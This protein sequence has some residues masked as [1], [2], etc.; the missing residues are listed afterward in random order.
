MGSGQLRFDLGHI[1]R[2]HPFKLGAL[3]Q[4]LSPCLFDGL[5]GVA[6]QREVVRKKLLFHREQLEQR[7][8]PRPLLP[9]NHQ[10][11]VELAAGLIDAADPCHEELAAEARD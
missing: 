2:S 3:D 4:K 6:A 10:H 1:R 5:L 11:G 7:R 8:F 9:F